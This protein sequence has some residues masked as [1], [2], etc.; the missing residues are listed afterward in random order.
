MSDFF[1]KTKKLILILGDI[2][3]LYLALYLTLIARYGYPINPGVWNRH[4]IPFSV[5]FLIWVI[6][7]FINDFY[8][9]RISY[10]T[11][12]LLDSLIRIFII[13]TVIAAVFFYFIYNP[14][15][16]TIR[17]QRVLVIDIVFSLIILF[18]WRKIFYN[19]IKSSKIANNIYI[20]GQ[21]SLNQT[22]I[23]EIKRRPQ[24]GYQVI[25]TSETPTDLNKFCLENNI[26]ILVSA[27]SLRDDSQTA[28]NIFSCLSL[29]I[30][31]YNINTFYELITN[32]IPVEHIEH[33]W[34]LENLTEHSKKFYEITKR[35]FDLVFSAFGLI[36]AIPLTPIIALIIKLESPGTIIF[37]QIRTGKNGRVFLAMK[38]RSMV[39]DAEKSGAQWAQK[40]DPRITRFGSLMRKTR[41]DEIPQLINILKG[42][43]SFVG[44]RPERPEFITILITEIPFYNE[45]LLVKPG[46]TGWAQLKGPTYGGSKTESLEKLKYDLYYIKN[47]SLLLDLSILLKTVKL[48]LGGKGQ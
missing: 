19:F 12:N 23:D 43:M 21:S 25:T 41:L 39:K 8:D 10:N 4:L 33:S 14:F 38:F 28:R 24:L 44:P 31:V 18:I 45:R 9:L 13:N 32:K 3:T 11:N 26:Y 20:I 6:V 47:R 22:L 17:P 29:G 34:F 30:D 1:V 27:Q 37:K 5:L 42:E 46:L 16:G 48:I 2:G 36:V 15:I 7:L 40:N 35:F